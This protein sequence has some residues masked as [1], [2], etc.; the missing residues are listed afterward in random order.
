MWAGSFPRSRNPGRPSTGR[1]R[2]RRRCS[3]RRSRR[4]RRG[5][6]GRREPRNR[7][8]RVEA[9]AHRR[10]A[11]VLS[12][13]DLQLGAGRCRR[14]E[15]H[16]PREP[17]LSL[18]APIEKLRQQRDE[19]LSM[20][21]RDVGRPLRRRHVRAGADPC[22]RGLV[23][24]RCGLDPV[25]G[26][27][28]LLEQTVAELERPRRREGNARSSQQAGDNRNRERPAHPDGGLSTTPTGRSRDLPPRGAAT[29]T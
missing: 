9:A 16:H 1:D 24:L 25:T 18:G 6:P 21:A 4:R 19:A 12:E 11:L 10:L 17:A 8:G 26:E 23:R 27:L 2:P 29:P 13:V 7:E 22:R 3:R 5:S 20:E 14:T 15:L 28:A